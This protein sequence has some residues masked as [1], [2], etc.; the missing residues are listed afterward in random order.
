MG[1]FVEFVCLQREKPGSWERIRMNWRT[2]FGIL[3]AFVLGIA[4]GF[5]ASRAEKRTLSSSEPRS[6]FITYPDGGKRVVQSLVV[7]RITSG[8][9]A[10]EYAPADPENDWYVEV[11]GAIYYCSPL[12]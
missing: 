3:M 10:K 6:V 4:V 1:A 8:N 12:K 5:T 7:K 2:N 9:A 11:G